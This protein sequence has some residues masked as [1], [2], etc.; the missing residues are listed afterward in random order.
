MATEARGALGVLLDALDLETVDRD[1]FRGK[2]P[3]TR[4]QRIFGGQVAGQALVAAG[5]T[6]AE[7]RVHSLHAYFL[8]PGDP[9]RP[10]VYEVDR[11]RDGRSYTTRRVVGIQN[12]RAIFNLQASFHRAEP[13]YDRHVASPAAGADPATLPRWRPPYGTES[14]DDDRPAPSLPFDLRVAPPAGGYTRLLWLRTNGELPDD[15]MLQA[16][17]AAYASDLTLLSVVAEAAGTPTER[18]SFLASLDHAMWFHR[19]F[20]V[21]RWMLYAQSS[22]SSGDGR[23]LTQGHLFDASGRLAI[24]VMQEGAVRP[25]RPGAAA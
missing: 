2:T 11:I 10:V 25:P 24:S 13:G 23:G 14:P 1:L 7:Q 9:T 17:V 16:C 3:P 15:P 8:R 22:P 20:R 4:L 18:P 5:R 21:D 12:G 19:P 6:V